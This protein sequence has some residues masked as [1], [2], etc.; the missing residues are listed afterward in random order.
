M[1]AGHI[2]QLQLVLR[3]AVPAAAAGVLSAA[4]SARL[5]EHLAAVCMCVMGGN[6]GENRVV[7]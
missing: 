2:H 4:V 5:L 7:G 1:R 6:G 3:M